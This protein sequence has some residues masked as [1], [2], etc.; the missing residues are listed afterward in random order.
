M[1]PHRVGVAGSR[2]VHVHVHVNDHGTNAGQCVSHAS[3]RANTNPVKVRTEHS[4]YS[5]FNLPSLFTHTLQ[6]CTPQIV[7][8]KRMK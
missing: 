8:L 5:D 3:A 7:A 1:N 6:I 4:N 2:T